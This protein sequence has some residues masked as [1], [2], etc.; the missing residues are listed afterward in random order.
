MSV[1]FDQLIDN[2]YFYEYFKKVTCYNQYES[3]SFDRTAICSRLL[4]T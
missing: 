3:I 1:G 2:M 4:R